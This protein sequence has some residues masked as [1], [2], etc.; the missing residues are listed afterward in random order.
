MGQSGGFYVDINTN[1]NLCLNRKKFYDLFDPN[2]PSSELSRLVQGI[3]LRATSPYARII[4][5][6]EAMKVK[7]AA[8]VIQKVLRTRQS[9]LTNPAKKR[10]RAFLAHIQDH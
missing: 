5:L 2:K 8:K 3:Q 6:L 7:P 10:L 1:Y 9:K 4:T